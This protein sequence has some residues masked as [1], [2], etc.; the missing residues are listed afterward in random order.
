MREGICS[1]YSIKP[2]PTITGNLAS[3][4]HA[5]SNKNAESGAT[6]RRPLL[7]GHIAWIVPPQTALQGPRS[8]KSQTA[9]EAQG[10]QGDNSE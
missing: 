3:A 4:L 7:L 2:S 10:N 5:C 8:N 6:T 9:I 1:A